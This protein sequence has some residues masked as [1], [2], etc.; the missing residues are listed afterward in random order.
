MGLAAAL[1][2]GGTDFLV[3]INARSVGVR[4]A[5]FFSQAIGFVI[6]TV[7]LPATVVPVFATSGVVWGLALLAAGLTMGGALALSQAF[8]IG[9]AAM[10][11]PLVTSYGAVTTLLSWISGERLGALTLIGLALCLMGVMLTAV[12]LG[13]QPDRSPSSLPAIAFALLA[14]F[15][16]GV[17]FWLQ[18]QYTLP[19]LGP[20]VSLWLG[21]AVG[22]TALLVLNADRRALVARPG[23]RQGGLLLVA[24]LLNLGGFSAFAVG[25]GS[26]SLAIVTVLSTL[27]GGIAALLAA[28]LL[29]ER[30]SP[31]QWLGVLTVLAGALVLHLKAAL[32][33]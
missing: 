17:G 10:V 11:A 27:S 30:L 19:V 6:F 29:R 28:L 5:V 4:R 13:R 1:C 9:K 31:L 33:G 22:L 21:Y 23:W 7:L 15:C 18:G 2:W 8:A 16:Y 12:S 14:A 3:G 25:A 20:S 24:S 26:G 32:T